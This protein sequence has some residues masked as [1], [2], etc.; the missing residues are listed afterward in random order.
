MIYDLVILG[1]GPAGYIA[2]LRAAQTGLKTAIVEKGKIGGMSLNWGFV[3]TKT[4]IESAKKFHLAKNLSHFGVEVSG[5]NNIH[6][7][8]DTVKKL[9]SRISDELTSGVKAYIESD[10]VEIIRGTAKIVSA[11]SVTVENRLIEAKNIIIATGSVPKKVGKKIPSE[12]IVEVSEIQKLETLP[13]NPVVYGSGGIAIEVA[14]FLNLL[15]KKVTIL[16]PLPDL[17]PGF[18]SSVKDFFIK[19]LTDTGIRLHINEDILSVKNQE[20]RTDSD[21]KFQFDKI[22][23]CNWREPVIPETSVSFDLMPKGTIRVNEY[24]QTSVE[25]IYAIGDVNGLSYLSQA[26]S[27]EAIVAVNHINGVKDGLSFQNFPLN[28]YTVPEAAQIGLTS[29]ELEASQVEYRVAELSMKNNAKAMIEGNNEGFVRILY[30][31]KYGEILGVHIVA[32]NATDMISEAQA[33]I[34][35]ESTIYDVAKI[36]HSHPT[37]S[38]VFLSFS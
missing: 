10:K 32:E 16:C 2:A 15:G 23:N 5:K 12:Q 14:Q 36:I 13:E 37:T 33:F 20:I 17:M 26:A 7:N 38:E 9:A 28:C 6:F 30:E 4:Y 21:N 3:H 34:A 29:E 31:E 35:S 27:S 19:K 18:D 11:N 1:S 25:N 8:W 22:I 24:M